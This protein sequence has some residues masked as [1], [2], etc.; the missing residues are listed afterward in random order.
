MWGL[1]FN[2][3]PMTMYEKICDFENLVAAFKLSQLDNRYKRKICGFT[4]SLEENLLRLR[5]ELQHEVYTPQPYSYFTLHEPKARDIAAPDFRDRIVQH[6]M[7]AQIEPIFEKKF[8]NDCYA[9]RTGRGTHFAKKRVKRFLMAARSYHGKSVQMYVLQCDVRKFFQS[10]SWDILLK[11]IK[12]DISDPQTYNL[13]E[14]IVTTHPS[15]KKNSIFPPQAQLSIFEVNTETVH[16]SVSIEKRIGLPIGNLTSQLFANLYLNELDHYMKNKL[17]IRW[18]GRYMDDFFVI[19]PDRNYLKEL[20]NTIGVFLEKEL[21]LKLHPKK[22]TIKNVK[23]GL[24]FVGYRI[25]YDHVLVRGSTLQRMERN[26]RGKVKQ[27]KDK[28]I[29][30]KKLMESKAS[31]IGH[32]KHA[33]TYGLKKKMFTK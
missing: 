32:L 16:K 7:V 21:Q 9:C 19:H 20:E 14:K 3:T 24:P 17:H 13:I 29:T 6:S 31:I 10:I 4:F 12:K 18:Y 15:E 28:W 8:I 27:N 22:L 2:T 23:D 5:W 30:D 25:F 33:N 11:I 26:Y 1:S